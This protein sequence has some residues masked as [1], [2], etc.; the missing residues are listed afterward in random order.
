MDL[1]SP[2]N[3]KKARTPSRKR[4]LNVIYFVDSN[5][6]HSIKI[7]LKS[8]AYIGITAI[9]LLLWSFVCTSLL[10][11]R[12]QIE[13]KK[14]SRISEL[15]STIFEYQTRY[16]GVYEKTYPKS[17]TLSISSKNAK[18]KKPPRIVSGPETLRK[19]K[20]QQSEPAVKKPVK[21]AL[22]INPKQIALEGKRTSPAINI[23][24]KSIRILDD[25]V[26]V[27]FAIQNTASPTRTEGYIWGVATLLNQRGK[28][29]RITSPDDI[30]HSTIGPPKNIQ[31][32]QKFSIRYYKTKSLRFAVN[33]KVTVT[34]I[35]VFTFQN[36]SVFKLAG[37]KI[38]EKSTTNSKL[39]KSLQI[40]S[41]K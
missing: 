29:V 23:R 6:T 34:A 1:L 12:L 20:P 39:S 14:N 30:E 15:L 9:S 11:S 4:L 25:A 36:D 3:Y 32:A 41:G 7:P 40:E 2:K 13:K 37:F 18:A 35:E 17:H 27:S 24:N 21:E 16:D 26:E 28:I 5:R 19:A 8:V 38:P 31:K 22:T 33:E 10:F